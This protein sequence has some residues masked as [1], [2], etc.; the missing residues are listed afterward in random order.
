MI[1]KCDFKKACGYPQ[2]LC[3]TEQAYQGMWKQKAKCFYTK[4]Y[5]FFSLYTLL[6]QAKERSPHMLPH[7]IY[8]NPSLI[9][10]FALFLRIDL[11]PGREN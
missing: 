3:I 10:L 5:L 2:Y 11:L 4:M 1:H 9:L 7:N 8:K 6:K